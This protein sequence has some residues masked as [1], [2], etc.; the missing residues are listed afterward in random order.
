[1]PAQLPVEIEHHILLQCDIVSLSVCRAVN[2]RFQVLAQDMFT[3]KQDHIVTHFLGPATQ[4]RYDLLR[5]TN[6][7][8]MGLAALAFILRNFGILR[9]EL[10]ISIP[11]GASHRATAFIVRVLGGTLV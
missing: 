3:C 6:A 7:I 2:H 4:Q 10:A 1:M 5:D 9:A 8:V 11:D